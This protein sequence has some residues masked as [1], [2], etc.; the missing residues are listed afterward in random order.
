VAAVPMPSA[1][2]VTEREKRR[3]CSQIMLLSR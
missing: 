1:S 2:V 3:L